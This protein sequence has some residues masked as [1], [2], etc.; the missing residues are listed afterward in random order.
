MGNIRTEV[1]AF[2]ICAGVMQA[3]HLQAQPATVADSAVAQPGQDGAPSGQSPPG[4]DDSP[5]RILNPLPDQLSKLLTGPTPLN[6]E[7]TIFLDLKKK[8][9]LLHTEVACTDCLLEMF[10]CRERTKE[11]EAVLWLRGKA[12]VVHSGLLALNAKPGTPVQFMPEF[13]APTGHKIDIFVNWVDD[14]GKLQRN[15]AR[16]WMRHSVSRY[17]SQKLDSPPPGVR[18]PLMELRFDPFNKEILWFGEMTDK[19]RDK[20]LSLWDNKD[21]Q[22]AI[23]K[24]HK[25]SQPHPMKADF[26]FTGSYEFQPENAPRKVYAAEGG[27]VVCVANFPSSMIDVR[28]QSS[29]NDGGQSYEAIGDKVPPQGTPVIVE[30]VPEQ[31]SSVAPKK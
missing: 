10:L 21:Y 12:F 2:L 28:E 31:K 3:S 7:K 18:L 4:P 9:V 5:Q 25:D 24:F 29:A 8:R 17:Y 11:H 22:A 1:A 15:D 14:K 16:D 30:L 27:Q 13:K 23:K 26:V 6:P 20:L 19:Q